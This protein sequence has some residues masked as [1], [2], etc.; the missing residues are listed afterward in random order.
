MSDKKVYL[1]RFALPVRRGCD[2]TR[3]SNFASG[4][5][6]DRGK[7]NKKEKSPNQKGKKNEKIYPCFILR[8]PLSRA[9]GRA[10]GDLP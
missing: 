8:D 3:F 2:L 7:L 10:A 4:F 1:C 5:L 6:F 9:P